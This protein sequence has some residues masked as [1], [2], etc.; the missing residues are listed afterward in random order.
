MDVK[1]LDKKSGKNLRKKTGKNIFESNS[2]NT[3]KNEGT[4]ENKSE[5]RRLIIISFKAEIM[6]NKK[7]KI[8]DNTT[9][10][11]KIGNSTQ[12]EIVCLISTETINKIVN[13]E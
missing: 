7:Y 12:A 9:N 5:T 1:Q 8:L 3:T 13:N 4:I 10:N 6:G 2:G 11:A